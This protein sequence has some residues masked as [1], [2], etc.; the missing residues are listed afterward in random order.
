[1]HG[2]PWAEPD[3]PGAILNPTAYK[4]REGRNTPQKEPKNPCRWEQS[5]IKSILER[6]KYTGCTVN[7]KT[8]TNSIW[9]RKKRDNPL[10]KQ[11]VFYNT[12]P[13]IIEQEVFDKV[14]EIR[15]Q[16]HR[17]TKTGQY[18]LRLGLLCG[19]QAENVLLHQQ[20]V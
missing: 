13:A 15:Q 3:C 11:A 10:D 12:H 17:R 18:L 2:G 20:Q 9:D 5:T 4:R 19:L 8:Y 6:R 16:R 7:F 1:M 14:Q